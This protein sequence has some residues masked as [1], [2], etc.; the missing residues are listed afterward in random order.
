M[1]LSTNQRIAVGHDKPYQ[2]DRRHHKKKPRKDRQNEGGC[3]RQ[4]DSHHGL[5]QEP[6]F[7]K[8]GKKHYPFHQHFEND[9]QRPLPSV[10]RATGRYC[11]EQ[12]NDA[13]RNGAEPERRRQQKLRYVESFLIMSPTRTTPDSTTRQFAP[14]RRRSR[15]TGELTN[16][17][18]SLP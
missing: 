12:Q 7:S 9:Q 4:S 16:L 14:R 2:P 11:D 15:P 3:R 8:Q 1:F 10:A 17:S 5:G 6:D 18:E 13:E